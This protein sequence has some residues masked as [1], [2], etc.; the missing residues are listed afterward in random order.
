MRSKGGGGQGRPARGAAAWSVT[1]VYLTHVRIWTPMKL[2]P[3]TICV[4]LSPR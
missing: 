1:E 3:P 4:T 2:A